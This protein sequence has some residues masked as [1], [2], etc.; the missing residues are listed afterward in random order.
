MATGHKHENWDLVSSPLLVGTPLT[1][2]SQKAAL[3]T[4]GKFPFWDA[5]YQKVV[6]PIFQQ[7]LDHL[8]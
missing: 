8:G 4:G 6:Q 1:H 5:K 7:P 3:L 2:I